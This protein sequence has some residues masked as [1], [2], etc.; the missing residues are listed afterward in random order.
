VCENRVVR[1]I[2]GPKSDEVTGKWIKLHNDGPN[3]LYTA[4]NIVR[5]SKWRRMGGAGH[6]ASMGEKRGTYR[7]LAGK[8]E[9]KRPLGTPRRRWYNIKM[10]LQEVGWV[11][12][13][14]Y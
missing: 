8:S 14:L 1:G 13:H 9:E 6:V 7:V 2:F 10:D 5:V 4:P 12:I 3:G 11:S